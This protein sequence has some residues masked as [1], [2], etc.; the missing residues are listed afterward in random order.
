MSHLEKLPL[1]P[2]S[3]RDFMISCPVGGWERTAFSGWCSIWIRQNLTSC[4]LCQQVFYWKLKKIIFGRS[5]P[6]SWAY[7]G[8]GFWVKPSGWIRPCYKNQKMHKNMP[9][10]KV[11]PQKHFYGS[12]PI[13]PVYLTLWIS[14][15]CMLILYW[16]CTCEYTF[17]M[18]LLFWA[19]WIEI[20]ISLYKPMHMCEANVV[21]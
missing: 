7:L 14:T 19:L 17:P 13:F 1:L 4:Y 21:V 8:D 16:L 5:Y 6:D 12:A 3:Y 11:K 2:V 18:P 15:L 9:T 20:S 10:I